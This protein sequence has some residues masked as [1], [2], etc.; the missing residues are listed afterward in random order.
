M[1]TFRIKLVNRM[2]DFRLLNS[3]L[4][5]LVE[6]RQIIISVQKNH[7]PNSFFVEVVMKVFIPVFFIEPQMMNTLLLYVYIYITLRTHPHTHIRTHIPPKRST[8]G[9][10]IGN[11]DARVRV[12]HGSSLVRLSRPSF[13]YPLLLL[14]P[15]RK[16]TELLCVYSKKSP[17]AFTTPLACTTLTVHDRVGRTQYAIR[18][19]DACAAFVPDE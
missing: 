19:C 17:L 4:A 5:V 6:K 12:P 14:G 8:V 3:V 7:R 13:Q 15:V 11:K 16:S 10:H 1:K 18:K 2:Y 9:L